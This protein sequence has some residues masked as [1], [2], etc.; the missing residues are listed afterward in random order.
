MKE[1]K[2]M[3]M[4]H[5]AANKESVSGFH[6]GSVSEEARLRQFDYFWGLDTLKL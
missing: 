4:H 3:K 5:G 6:C 1:N 2:I